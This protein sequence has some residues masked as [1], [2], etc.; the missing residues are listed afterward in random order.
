MT[1]DF[2]FARLDRSALFEHDI[3]CPV[4]TVGPH[5]PIYQ[6]GH[7]DD[8]GPRPLGELSDSEDHDDHGADDRGDPL[9][10]NA[11]APMRLTVG[12]SGA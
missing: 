9:A 1:Q 7:D 5:E 4:L 12:V 3:L 8:H 11:L 2:R 6:D 10:G